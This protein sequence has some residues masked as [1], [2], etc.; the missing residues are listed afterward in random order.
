MEIIEQDLTKY[1]TIRTKSYAKYFTIISGPSQQT[2][3]QWIN[4]SVT[5]SRIMSWSI[6]PKESGRLII[7]LQMNDGQR[8]V[9]LK[10][11]KNGLIRKIIEEVVFVP[12]IEGIEFN[13]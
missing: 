3:M 4:G 2:S 13:E 7:P 5:N 11:T 6:A 1:S 9:K 8:L 10:K 12:M